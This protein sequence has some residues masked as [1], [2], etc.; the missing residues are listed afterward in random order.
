MGHFLAV[1]A[2]RTEDADLVCQAITDYCVGHGCSCDSRDPAGALDERTDLSIHGAANGW[3]RVLWP[4]YFNIHDFALCRA[5]SAEKRLTVSTVHVYDGDF[6]E[7][8]FLDCGRIV[9][10]FSSWPDYFAESPE[11]AAR[12]NAEWTGDPTALAEFA[13]IPAES[14]SRYLVHVPVGPPAEGVKLGSAVIFLGDESEAAEPEPIKAYEGDRFD[15]ENFW[16]FTDF[17]RKLGIRYPDP[18]SEGI[19]RVL[20][21]SKRLA[22]KLPSEG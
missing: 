22:D 13:G 12:A 4:S 7:H 1:S 3:V 8:L 10:K 9:H 20:R 17:W 21:L 18:P 11:D 5:I 14:I 6:W 15:L 2:V 19:V 16:V